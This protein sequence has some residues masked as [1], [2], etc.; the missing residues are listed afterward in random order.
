MLDV[1]LQ[2][3]VE[4]GGCGIF[5][6]CIKVYYKLLFNVL[7]QTYRSLNPINDI[8]NSEPSNVGYFN[9]PKEGIFFSFLIAND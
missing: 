1:L 7:I 5:I 2:N 8:R 9:L 4:I 3:P 6:W